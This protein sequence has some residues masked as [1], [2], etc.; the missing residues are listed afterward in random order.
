V[1]EER[2]PKILQALIDRTVEAK[3]YFTD[4]FNVYEG[5]IYWGAHQVAPGKS[6]TYT[7]E[8]VNADLRHYLARLV[9]RSR[10]FSRCIK[11]LRRAV[12]LFVHFYNQHR[13][14]CI[15]NPSYPHPWLEHLSHRF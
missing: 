7:V 1:C 8:G 10:C 6:Q 13:L 2:T 15:Q 12:A 11:A 9:R 3:H 5:L 4:A 14:Q